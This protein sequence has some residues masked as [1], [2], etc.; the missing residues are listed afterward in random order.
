[1]SRPQIVQTDKYGALRVMRTFHEG[2]RPLHLLEN[3]AYVF[4]TGLPVKS[5]DELRKAIPASALQEALDWF[6]HRFD[7]D[8]SPVKSI[9]VL[10]NNTVVY[11][12]GSPVTSI[13]DIVNFFEPGPFREAALLAFASKLAEEKKETVHSALRPAK[14]PVS[15]AHKK[16][17]PKK[18]VASKEESAAPSPMNEAQATAV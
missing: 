2:P 7:V 10:S 6:E 9:K 4:D 14:K 11:D 5:K 3:G 17:P 16:M 18:A 13:D 12:D 15:K 8:K 1:M